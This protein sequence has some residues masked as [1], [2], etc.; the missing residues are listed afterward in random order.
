MMP[1]STIRERHQKACVRD[2][3]QEREYP[4]REERLRGP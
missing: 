2:S 4:F 3:Y 1:I